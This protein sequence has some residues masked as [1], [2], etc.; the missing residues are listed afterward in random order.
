M[1]RSLIY[2]T[3][4]CL[5]ALIS[6][7]YLYR[8]AASFEN[9]NHLGNFFYFPIL[10]I[11]FLGINIFLIFKEDKQH[12]TNRYILTSSV[13]IIA[14]IIAF[15]FLKP[16]YTF[17]EA[18]SQV[19]EKFDVPVI[20]NRHKV[21]FTAGTGQNYKEIYQ[22]TVQKNASFINYSFDPYSGELYEIE[23]DSLTQ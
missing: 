22:I 23:T 2:Y 4:C 3:L 14:I 16:N 11:T 10:L 18:E 9:I 8:A 6:S 5:L 7:I 15:E 12:L 1:K 17:Q 13:L 21:I 19:H 20:E